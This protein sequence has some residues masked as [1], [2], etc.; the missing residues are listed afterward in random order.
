MLADFDAEIAA[1]HVVVVDVAELVAGYMI[2]WPERGSY[3]IDNIA[4]DPAWQGQGLGRQL[5][6]YAVLKAKQL[7]LPAIRLYTNVAMTENLTMYAHLGFIET[8]RA[9]EDGFHRVYLRLVVAQA[10]N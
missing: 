3:F 9:W 5:L 7:R 4:V 10:G 2:A 8:H 1:N 6:D